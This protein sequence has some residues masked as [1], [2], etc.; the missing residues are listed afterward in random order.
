MK[1]NLSAVFFDIDDTLYST[2]GFAKTARL[3]SIHAMIRAG[4]NMKP[5]RAYEELLEVI[6]EFGANYKDHYRKLL[7]RIPRECYEPVN[8]AVL[9]ATAICAYH[10][11]KSKYLRPY[12]DVATVLGEFSHADLVLGIISAG[13]EIKQAEKLVRL[14]LLKFINP[15]AIF[16]TDQIG[17]GKAN[18]KLY[19]MACESLDIPPGEC[20]YVGDNPLNDVDPPNEINMVTVLSK[21]GGKYSNVVGKTEPNYVIRDMWELKDIIEEDFNIIPNI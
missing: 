11:T 17:I 13:L 20:M 19:Q 8:S 4:L 10:E 1:R 14:R 2:S 18:F 15:K 16:I 6:K 9:I 12:E 7:L 5:D 3:N 21:R